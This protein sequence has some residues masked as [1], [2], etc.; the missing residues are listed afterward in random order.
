L[1]L[2]APASSTVDTPAQGSSACRPGPVRRARA[3]ATCWPRVD[4]RSINDP[5]EA[6]CHVFRGPK[7][8]GAGQG[9]CTQYPPPRW[10]FRQALQGVPYRLSM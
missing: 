4:T 5:E 10:N 2:E 6:A 8:P 1:G 9:R 7:F 3:Y